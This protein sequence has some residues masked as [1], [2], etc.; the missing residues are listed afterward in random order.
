M[1]TTLRLALADTRQ[2][3]RLRWPKCCAVCT[4]KQALQAASVRSAPV[5]APAHALRSGVRLQD[6][7]LQLSPPLCPQH[8]RRH[9]LAARLLDKTP[10]AHGLRLAALACTVLALVLGLG[11]ALGLLTGHPAASARLPLLA[12]GL[13]LV[14]LPATL[15]LWW[16]R[17]HVGL[18]IVGV[19][20][21]AQALHLRFANSRYADAFRRANAGV[22]HPQGPQARARARQLRKRR[23]QLLGLTLLLALGV[24]AALPHLQP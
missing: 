22:G 3:G 19:E 23:L 12:L 24:L 10:L 11:L 16:A 20:P 14:G 2:Q 18:H 1:S 7:A 8:A 6:G 4:S 15:V 13:G 21:G 9:S 17:R 5:P